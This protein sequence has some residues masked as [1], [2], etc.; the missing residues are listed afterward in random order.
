MSRE[1]LVFLIGL[2]IVFVPVAGI[3]EDWKVYILSTAGAILMIIG[4]FLRRSEYYRRIDHGNGER[5]TD[6]FIETTKN[7]FDNE[8]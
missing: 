5:G 3:P 4:Y 8:S 2:V 7:M 1:T 6:S